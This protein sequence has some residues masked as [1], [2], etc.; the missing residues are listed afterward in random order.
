MLDSKQYK[1]PVIV[2]TAN[3][4]YSINN[5]TFLE[6]TFGRSNNSLTG[7]AQAQNNTRPS[8]CTSGLPSSDSASLDKS[9][10]GALPLI[11][12]DA[13]VINKSYFAFTALESVNPPIWDG[14]RLRMVPSFSWGGR[15]TNSP[16][17][18]P[19]PGYFNTMTTW[20]AASNITKVIGRHS[21]KAGIY[22][23]HSYKAQQRQGWAGTIDFSNSTSNPLDSQFGFS[24]AILGVFTSF[25]QYSKYV[26]GNYV[27]TNLDFYIQDNWKFN[28]RITLDYGVR[29][30][31][32][33]PQYDNLGQASNFLFDQWKQS[34]APYIYLAG[35]P[36]GATT[37]SSSARQAKD[38]RTGALLGTNTSLA[39]G[40]L[41][42][43][44]G[45]LTNGLFLSGQGGVPTTT[46]NWP[47]L[48]VG[49]R[50]GIAYDVTG[51]QRLVLRGG[52]GLMFDRTAGNAV[53]NQVQNPPTLYNVT[54]RYANLQSMSG[55]F[56]TQSASS[57]NVYQLESGLPSTWSWN[58]GAQFM[59]PLNTVVAAEY[60]GQYSFNL[61]ESVG[62][63]HTDF[64]AAFLPQN[65]DP[66]LTSSIPGSNQLPIDAIRP[67]RGFGTITT[68]MP[69]GWYYSH[70]LQLS[71]TRRFAKGLAFG[72]NDTI[73]L[74]NIGS[75]GSRLQHNADGT[76]SERSDQDLADDLLNNYIATRHQFKGNFIYD[77][78]GLK[79]D[80][81]WQK[82]AKWPLSNWRISGIWTANTPSSYTISYNFQNGAS[83]STNITGS[84]NYSGR[85]RILGDPGGGCNGDDIYR[86]FNTSAFAPA[87]Q[88]SVGL[89]SPG[90][91][92]LR[93]CF[94]H[95]LDLA[96]ARTFNFADF[97]LGEGRRIEL[98][99]DA[100]NALNL[101]RITGRYTIMQVP[102]TT[103]STIQNLP[104]DAS[105]N[106]I[107]TRSLP[108]NAG[109]GV[110]N[111][112]Q[113][114]RNLQAQL[115]FYF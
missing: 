99:L 82:I 2:M 30:V 106:L 12:P 40:T 32:Q 62:I 105:G 93:G 33:Q 92:Y 102:S 15:I 89:E 53:M 68:N 13:G 41:V 43:N 103:D 10:L 47:A 97:H 90:G 39:I 45:N 70:S 56:T 110:A 24:N 113:T 67:I 84:S 36:G 8:F 57:L 38:P 65:Q 98:R 101:S 46:Y 78:P 25:N 83:N 37:C 71:I 111:A 104:F 95:T 76:W 16:P 22:Y 114:P 54:M 69:S 109:F 29:L 14:T 6:G 73:M 42:P 74:K 63:N 66:T 35:C 61:V 94:N 4:N 3:I 49:P 100:F 72:F 26:E 108:K 86:Q 58:G 5:S 21:V 80:A 107:S 27:Y 50:F 31:H 64:G 48:K 59:A 115:R 85:V 7:C 18:F 112:Y 52:G 60:V 91:G 28:D 96:L 55:A 9:G 81:L 11:Y 23:T 34:D 1:M 77:L 44:S 19:F 79:G 51:R 17:N 87:L 88:G 20:D 75:S